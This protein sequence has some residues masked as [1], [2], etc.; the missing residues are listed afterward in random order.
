MLLA[1]TMAIVVN[2]I[3]QVWAYSTISQLGFMI[4]GLSAG[5]YFAGVF[6]LTTHAVFKSLLFLCAGVFIHRFHSN[7]MF[8]IGKQNG[9]QM[10]IPMIC[11]V[12]AGGSL[13]GLWPFSGFFSKEVIL[14][15]LAG[16]DNPIW[17]MAG[18]LGVFF[19]AYYTFRLIFIILFPK[20]IEFIQE[21]A[22]EHRAE[23]NIMN[24]P[25]II[26]A[27]LTLILG[28]FEHG[29]SN[30]LSPNNTENIA[31]APKHWLLLTASGLSVLGTILA[32]FEFGRRK[33]PQT[34]FIEQWP[35]VKELL[36][37]RWYMD[38]FYHWLLAALIDKGGSRI[39]A[40]TDKNV[41][42]GGVHVLSDNIIKSGQLMSK[43]HRVLIQTKLMVML[44]VV[45]YMALY[46][47]F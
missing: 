27:M 26:L 22:K 35:Y 46:L 14:S 1:S 32:W 3:K 13:S 21:H 6:H 29:L 34:G 30:F 16:L 47:V 8:D 28:F 40:R 4:M 33:A 20:T 2:D 9:R 45:F 43:W 23:I 41:I 18:L 15:Q 5:S 42:D 39:C 38:R 25:L 44:I 17:L 24:A 36:L 12:I 19:T 10:K 7:D 11:M 31:L 37:Q